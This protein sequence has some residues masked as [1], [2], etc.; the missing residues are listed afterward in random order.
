MKNLFVFLTLVFLLSLNVNATDRVYRT[1]AYRIAL[2]NYGLVNI[3]GT[4][5]VCKDIFGRSILNTYE[6]NAAEGLALAERLLT[7][8]KKYDLTGPRPNVIVT[9]KGTIIIIWLT[10][11][12][13]VDFK[14]KI[15]VAKKG[16]RKFS[17]LNNKK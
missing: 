13:W 10:N 1:K 5:I 7:D 11:C 9:S 16:V 15:Q 12:W 6:L 3:T 8:P 17:L 4:S 14:D 2:I